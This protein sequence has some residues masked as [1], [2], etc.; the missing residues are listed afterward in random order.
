MFHLMGYR[1][2]AWQHM[3]LVSKQ[4][5]VFMSRGLLQT[6]GAQWTSP[7]RNDVVV[8]SPRLEKLQMNTKFPLMRNIIRFVSHAC[9][10]GIFSATQVAGEFYNETLQERYYSRGIAAVHLFIITSDELSSSAAPSNLPSPSHRRRR[11]L[12]ATDCYS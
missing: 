6:T 11:G 2:H 3:R 5:Q 8:N 12:G 10:S 9:F 4:I 1:Q 7:A